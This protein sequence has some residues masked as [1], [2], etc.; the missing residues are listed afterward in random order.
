MGEAMDDLKLPAMKCQLNH[1]SKSDGSVILAQGETVALVSV[2][3]P[4]ELKIPSQNIEKAILEVLYNRK[5]GKT[6][7]SDRFKENI[8][9]QTCEHIIQT[10]AHPRTAISITVQEI[11]D[12]G[13]LMS[14]SLNAVCIAFIASGIAM[15]SL[16][17]AVCCSID[18]E[19]KVIMGPIK[20][21]SAVFTFVFESSNR[22]LITC[23]TERN[24]NNEAYE[25][26]LLKS[27]EA[28]KNVFKYYRDV[29][30][31]YAKII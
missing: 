17:A 3:G 7:I 26:A 14:C 20:D 23:F 28:S 31:K 1:L 12:F 29:V 8:I 6:S 24:Y 27:R 30:S 25:E 5:S 13:G 2:N 22:D 18:G 16:F 4:L 15:K 9:R 21:P 10:N 11:E 19:G